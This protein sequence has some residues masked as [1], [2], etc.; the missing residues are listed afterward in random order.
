MVCRCRDSFRINISCISCRVIGKL[1]NWDKPSR[2]DKL[3][4]W[5]KLFR[6]DELKMGDKLINCG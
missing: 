2:K 4:S 3:L 1:R 5:D 6:R